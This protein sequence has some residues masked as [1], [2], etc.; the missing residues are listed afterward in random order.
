[1]KKILVSGAGGYVG[2]VMCEELLKRNY[3]VYALDRFFFGLDKLSHIDHEEFN[4]IQDDIRYFDESILEG[5]DIVIDLAGLSNDA[6]AEINPKFTKEI[7]CDGSIRLAK[8]SKK[9]GVSQYVYSSSASVYGAGLKTSLTEV[10]KLN[11]ITD[12]AKSKVLVEEELLK[13]HDD[14][15]F[16]VTLLRNSTIYGLSPRMRFDLAINIMSLCGWRDGVVY[17]M[18]D[19]EQWRPFIHVRDVVS[20]FL[21]CLEKPELSSGQIFNVGSNE[22]NFKIKSIA[23]QVASSLSNKP[24]IIYVPDNPD[25]RTYNVNFDKI[26][27]I[28]GFETKW[29]I[30]SGV[31]EIESSLTDGSLKSDD[32][33]THTLKWY[34]TLLDWH[35]KINGLL[36]KNKIL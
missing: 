21:L 28:L 29:T 18:G 32:P 22:Q 36:Y 5:I 7:N 26:K 31:E 16:S 19:G 27:S 17:I 33:T 35:E 20:A 8:L 30:K 1:M 10:E 15:N 6:T 14:D 4:I 23:S 2:S 34:Q 9:F 3:Q 24:K 11:P 25:Q 13:L 12:Y